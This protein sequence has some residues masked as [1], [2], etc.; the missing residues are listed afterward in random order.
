MSAKRGRPPLMNNG[1]RHDVYLNDEAVRKA[2]VIGGGNVSKGIRLALDLVY[3]GRCYLCLQKDNKATRIHSIDN[4]ITKGMTMNSYRVV[5]IHG[6]E[7][8]FKADG[9]LDA[10]LVADLIIAKE[11][12]NRDYAISITDLGA[13]S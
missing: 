9:I 11:F 4:A 13:S 12:D 6:R 7:F 3:A 10:Q 1:H 2:R 5:T 8:E